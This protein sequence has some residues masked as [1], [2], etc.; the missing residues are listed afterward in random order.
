MVMIYSIARETP[1]HNLE[2][3]PIF[4]LEDI[5]GRVR[6]KGLKVEVYG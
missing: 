3:I 2:K 5:A 6:E 1:V 4:E